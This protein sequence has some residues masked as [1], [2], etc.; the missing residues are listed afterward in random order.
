VSNAAVIQMT[1]SGEVQTNL[2]N[3]HALLVQAARQGARLAALPENFALMGRH[4]QDKLGIAELQ[5]GT[6]LGDGPLQSW[7]YDTARELG[8]WIVAGTLPIKSGVDDR[9]AAASLVVNE[10]GVLQ[11]RYDKMHLFDVDVSDATAQYRESNTITAGSEPVCVDTPIG[12]LGLAI[13]YD[14]RFPEL[15]RLLNAQGAEVFVLPS[16]FT[17]PT[18]RAHWDVLL[19]ARAI[20]NLS[21][22]LAPAQTGKHDNGR[23]TWGHSMLVNYWGEVIAHRDAAPGVVIGDI[24]LPALHVQRNTFPALRHRRM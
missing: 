23:E 7:L 16:A 10:Q 20:E 6:S 21:Y 8:M 3:A 2:D 19:R 13:C 5:T 15:F 1:S 11:A 17:V 24:D 22:L 18:G 14:V 4:E 9:V 12:K